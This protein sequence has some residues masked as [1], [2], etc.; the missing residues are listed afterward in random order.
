MAAYKV[1]PSDSYS[2]ASDKVDFAANEMIKN[3]TINLDGA[4]LASFEEQ[5]EETVSDDDAD[6][7]ICLPLCLSTTSTGSILNEKKDLVLVINMTGTGGISTAAELIKFAQAVN[8][9]KKYNKW[10]NEAGEVTLLNDIDMTGTE[11]WT[12]IGDVDNSAYTTENPF[13]GINPFKGVFDG[14]GHT[15]K[16]L[17]GSCDLSNRKVFALFGAVENATIKNLTVGD[18]DGNDTWTFTG[19]A[20][21]ASTFAAIV[22]AAKNSTIANCHNYVNIQFNADNLQNQTVMLAGVVGSME[23]CTVGGETAAEGCTNH[24]DIHTGRLTN[25]ACGQTCLLQGGIVGLVSK[26]ETNKVSYCVNH[27]HISAPA[28]RTGGVIGN[29]VRGIIYRCDNRGTVEDDRIGQYE[30][31]NDNTKCNYKRMGGIVA[32]TDDCRAYPNNKIIECT[33]Y[34]LILCHT[35]CRTGGIVGHNNYALDGCSNQGIIL[36]NLYKNSHGPGWLCGY[37][38]ASTAI[39]INAQNCVRGGKLG[40]YSVYKDNPEAAPETTNDNAFCYISTYY[41]PAINK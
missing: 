20:P 2:F 16:G 31:I 11:L 19:V 28:C 8:K 24:G 3:L 9:G 17:D 27:G 39:W 18:K 36:G 29:L 1:I 26:H 32:G 41:N 22:G 35:S 38:G 40:D 4:K 34:G 12:P 33:N 15:I 23:N 37:C 10:T 5:L 21:Q 14:Q 6:P 13:V 7:V 30:A 25:T